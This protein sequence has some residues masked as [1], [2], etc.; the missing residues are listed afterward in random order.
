MVETKNLLRTPVLLK[1][2]LSG[3]LGIIRMIILD[4]EICMALPAQLYCRWH[5]VHFMRKREQ[6]YYVSRFKI[7][8]FMRHERTCVH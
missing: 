4:K 8:I 5:I 2:M 7:Q 3:A 6:P 1:Y